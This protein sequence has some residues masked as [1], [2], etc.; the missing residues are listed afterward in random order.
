MVACISLLLA[1]AAPLRVARTRPCGDD[2]A[3]TVAPL[4]LASSSFTNSMAAFP[5]DV[6]APTS[7][8]KVACSSDAF[9]LSTAAEGSCEYSR[10][11]T[12]RA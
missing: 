6:C 1:K 4:A 12:N 9:S 5:W 2:A 10:P 11:A 3:S 8:T 7:E